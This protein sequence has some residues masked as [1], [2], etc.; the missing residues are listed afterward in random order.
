MKAQLIGQVFIYV[1]TIVLVAFILVYGYKAITTFKEKAEQVSFIQ[2]K[3]DMQNTVE[4]L[5]LDFGSVKIKEFT[6][7]DDIDNVCFVKNFPSMPTLSNTKYPII[8]DSVNSG[9]D[10]NVFLVGKGVEESFNA[11]KISIDGN[12]LCVSALGDIIK[13]RMEGKGD[14]TL[15]SLT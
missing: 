5:S 6:V 3:N 4:V 12:F 2:F 14:H 1:I 15:I 8:E 10:K 13:L 9:V 11:G 7:P